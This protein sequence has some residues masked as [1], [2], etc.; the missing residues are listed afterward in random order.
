MLG[1]I[2]GVAV[3]RSGETAGTVGLTEG[4]AVNILELE[5]TGEMVGFRDLFVGAKVGSKEG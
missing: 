1:T 5:L 3:D 2:L 4:S